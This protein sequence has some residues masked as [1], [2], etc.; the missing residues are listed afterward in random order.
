MSAAIPVDVPVETGDSHRRRMLAESDALLAQVEELR[1]AD[2][3]ACPSD[4]AEAV[5][6]LQLRQGR[7][8]AQ[9]PRTL[10]TAHRLVFAVQARLMAANPRSP[11]PRVTL[12]RPAGQPTISILRPGGAWKF[13][14]LPASPPSTEP[15]ALAEWRLLV[16][17]TVERGLD[18]WTCAQDEAVNAARTG[19]GTARALARARAAWRNY[20][21]LRCEA[22]VLL[23]HPDGSV[24]AEPYSLSAGTGHVV[25]DSIESSRC[26]RS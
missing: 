12:D 22:E 2:R 5:R 11:R 3:S 13:L 17:L 19:D 10:R 6:S 23:N 7:V 18:R 14:V 26:S 1:L 20:W 4:L 25:T 15:Q 16:E 9:L 21:D 24:R 8:D